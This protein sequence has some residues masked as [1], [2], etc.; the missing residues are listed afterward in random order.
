VTVNEARYRQSL[1][2]RNWQEALRLEKELIA[3][4]KAGKEPGPTHRGSS[5]NLILADALDEFVKS[6]T[7]RVAGRTTQIDRGTSE[8]ANTSTMVLPP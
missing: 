7:G 1:K 3:R 2:T 5:A 8:G 6:R 4:I